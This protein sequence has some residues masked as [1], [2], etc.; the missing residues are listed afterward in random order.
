M[1]DG[2]IAVVTASARFLGFLHKP[3]FSPLFA[4]AL[5]AYATCLASAS[6]ERGWS[7]W[8]VGLQ[9]GEVRFYESHGA[10]SPPSLSSTVRLA[11][12]PVTGLFFGTYG[13]EDGSLVALDG[14]GGIH[15]KILRR[16]VGLLSL[17]CLMLCLTRRLSAPRPLRRIRLPRNPS[18][19]PSG[20]SCTWSR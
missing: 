12:P 18:P 3:P 2:V 11:K 13:R 14:T 15:V 17:S 7:G 8:A 9:T 6:L 19:S 16:T 5:P 10:E 1:V 20:P 4:L